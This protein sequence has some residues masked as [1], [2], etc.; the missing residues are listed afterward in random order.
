MLLSGAR[1]LHL[2]GHAWLQF[3]ADGTGISVGL[4]ELPVAAVEFKAN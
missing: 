3:G 1:L 4:P 2:S